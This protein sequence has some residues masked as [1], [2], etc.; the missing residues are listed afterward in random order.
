MLDTHRIHVFLAAAEEASFS[1]AAKRLKMSQPAVSLQIQSLEAQLGVVLFR[2]TGRAVELTQAGQALLPLARQ[3]IE[4]ACHIEETMRQMQGRLM[5]RLMIGCAANAAHY[6]LPEI[7]LQF[8]E[9]YPDV[10]I[11]VQMLDAQ[12]VLDRLVSREL[13]VG[14]LSFAPPADQY[15]RS[16]L[17]S[18][19]FWLLAP[20]THPLAARDSVSLQDLAGVEVILGDDGSDSVRSLRESM[21]RVGAAPVDWR[22]AM[23]LESPK[24]VLGAVARGMGVTLM[25]AVAA[26]REVVGDELK[27]IPVSEGPLRYSVFCCRSTQSADTCAKLGFCDYA[28][29]PQIRKVI[30]DLCS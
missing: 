8:K 1:C 2:R 30:E 10:R 21:A 16:E 25:S 28:Q 12:S 24:A 14:V 7:A 18:D 27:V 3:L 9:A 5:G 22:V 19:E 29:I 13:D 6:V 17:L 15:H 26:R 20:H 11:S 4:M 23:E